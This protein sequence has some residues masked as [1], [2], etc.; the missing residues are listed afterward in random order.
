MFQPSMNSKMKLMKGQMV[1]FQLEGKWMVGFKMKVWNA[2]RFIT[3]SSPSY[4]LP[5]SK[6]PLN[7]SISEI[8]VFVFL[9]NEGREESYMVM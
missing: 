3:P 2:W 8:V 9:W 4:S 6:L 5:F 1:L 7:L